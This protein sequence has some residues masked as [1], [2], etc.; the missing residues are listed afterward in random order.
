[1]TTRKMKNFEDFKIY[2]HQKAIR[3]TLPNCTCECFA[4]GKVHIRTCDQC[5]HGWVAH[6]LD[7]LSTRHLYPSFQVEVVQFNIVFD[8]GSLILYG[9]QAI[10]TRLKILLDR[11]FSVLKHDEVIQVLHGLGWMYEDYARGYVLQAPDGKV[12]EEWDMA[13]REEETLILQQFLRF[14]ETK[15]ITEVMI[16]QDKNEGKIPQPQ[17]P[18]NSES[19]IR[20]FIERMNTMRQ[21]SVH[22]HSVPSS[23][24][25]QAPAF[26]GYTSTTQSEIKATEPKLPPTST[27]S[28]STTCSPPPR[29]SPKSDVATSPLPVAEPPVLPRCSPVPKPSPVVSAVTTSPDPEELPKRYILSS[30]ERA[31][32][33]PSS[34]SSYLAMKLKHLRKSAQPRRKCLIPFTINSSGPKQV[35]CNL[36]N[37]AFYNKGTWKIHYSSVHLKQKY[38]C[39]IEG[40]N[41]LFS[42]LR[43]RNRHSSNPNPKIHSAIPKQ[44]VQI[45]DTAARADSFLSANPTASVLGNLS[46]RFLSPPIINV[47]DA[48]LG[49]PTL[50]PPTLQSPN[51]LLDLRCPPS[52][53][54]TEMPLPKEINGVTVVAPADTDSNSSNQNY[55]SEGEEKGDV[56]FSLKKNPRKCLKPVKL[57]Q[58]IDSDKDGDGG[59]H[60]SEDL[61]SEFRFSQGVRKR[62]SNTPTRCL[63]ASDGVFKEE[64]SSDSD[65]ESD[66][67]GQ[68]K[69]RRDS[70]TVWQGES[71]SREE[72]KREDRCENM[73]STE[74]GESDSGEEKLQEE[75]PQSNDVSGDNERD[76]G[77]SERM[78]SSKPAENSPQRDITCQSENRITFAKLMAMQMMEQGFYPPYFAKEG[79][80][81]IHPGLDNVHADGMMRDGHPLNPLSIPPV[82]VDAESNNSS[83]PSVSSS[84]GI[85]M[86]GDTYMNSSE[87]Y[88]MKDGIPYCMDCAKPFQST[89]GVKTHYQ[90]V[91]L[92]IMHSC[93][94][95]GCNAS[96]PSKRS[97]DRHSSN[98]N[99]HRKLLAK[100]PAAASYFQEQGF[101]QQFQDH[102]MHQ[103]YRVHDLVGSNG[104]LGNGIQGNKIVRNGLIPTDCNDNRAGHF[105]SDTGM[106]LHGDSGIQVKSERTHLD[107]CELDRDICSPTHHSSHSENCSTQNGTQ[108]REMMFSNGFHQA[109]KTK[110][111]ERH[112]D[113][114]DSDDAEESSNGIRSNND[115]AFETYPSQLRAAL[116]HSRSSNNSSPETT[117]VHDAASDDQRSLRC[118][119]C[120]VVSHSQQSLQEHYR[121]K[122]LQSVHPCKVPGC[123][124]VFSSLHNC[125]QHSKNAE[126]HKHLISE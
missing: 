68:S 7:K 67:E 18:P 37:K 44:R 109:Q 8:I 80:S 29:A 16:Q 84:P 81:H 13:C 47:Q 119:I 21:L 62:K 95:S 39:T 82:P 2:G 79:G 99:L 27:A 12:L 122:H 17:P 36:C 40:C 87:T 96:F 93:T 20:A 77:T 89:H 46:E 69:V 78:V 25:S 108:H 107:K 91:H 118:D 86:A 126:L 76:T 28:S 92:K 125:V 85:I 55:Q 60:C 102:F 48:S 50:V 5:K 104:I 59:R 63:A 75:D 43:S 9:T 66:G 56:H 111:S 110:E 4:P 33:Q 121:D 103:V 114:E 52:Q 70:E 54:S 35:T 30:M 58:K 38:K 51:A 53:C 23:S 19:D 124:M 73:D 117:T 45:S 94:V 116:E 15:S 72:S 100:D 34:S 90:N 105:H 42:S 74:S 71:E 49:S 113:E 98:I 64:M 57:S 106:H 120:K 101:H 115:E 22:A 31:S 88:I 14:G 65:A 6:A 61:E 97:R 24:A 32:S 11:L 112:D 123:L 10:P 3:C 41:M 83:S 1:M 26:T